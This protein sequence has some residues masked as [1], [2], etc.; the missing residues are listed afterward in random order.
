MIVLKAE[1]IAFEKIDRC[2]RWPVEVAIKSI[3][4]GMYIAFGG[5]LMGLLKANGYGPLIYSAGFA[6]G[7]F[8]VVLAQGELFTGNCLI[9]PFLDN[10]TE[11]AFGSVMLI[12]NY[13]FNFFG[14][15]VIVVLLANLS[16]IDKTVFE[17][18]A[19]AKANIIFSVP[20]FIE[21]LIKGF[22]CNI[23]VCLAVWIANYSGFCTDAV[24]KTIAVLLPVMTFVFCGFEHSVA[25]M[26]F[27]PFGVLVGKISVIQALMQILIVSVGNWFGGRLVGVALKETIIGEKID[28][29]RNN[30][31]SGKCDNC[32]NRDNC[33]H[34]HNES[35]S[36]TGV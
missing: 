29:L 23:L 21:L 7:L 17:E 13:I 14:A 8:L 15:G 1:A 20:T 36:E 22:L 19:V 6:L 9:R 25:N 10:N 33:D 28:F 35:N 11:K 24:N 5:L 12:E 16:N 31:E 2:V 34:C 3:L 32:D 26:F 30:V 4:A 27:L 18:I